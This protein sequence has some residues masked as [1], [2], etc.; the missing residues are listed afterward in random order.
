[1]RAIRLQT[2]VEK[3]HTLRLELP[4]DV[5]EGPAEV[6]VL[7]PETV[8]RSRIPWPISW[9]SSLNARGRFAARKRSTKYLRE[10]RESWER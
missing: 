4:E 2:Q 8:E 5:E 10:E 6:I 9:S 7:V 3:D 1:M